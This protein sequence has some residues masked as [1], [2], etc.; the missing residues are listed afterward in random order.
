[1]KRSA[2]RRDRLVLYFCFGALRLVKNEGTP[3]V[4][5]TVFR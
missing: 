4:T 3:I 2:S 5:L 1:V